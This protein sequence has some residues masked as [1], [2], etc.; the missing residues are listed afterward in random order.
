MYQQYYIKN[1]K[2]EGLAGPRVLITKKQIVM[3]V[4]EAMKNQIT[5]RDKYNSY[6]EAMDHLDN[7]GVVHLGWV[8]AGITIPAH[9]FAT[10]VYSNRS[11][12]SCLYCDPIYRVAYSVDMG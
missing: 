5:I 12:S 3:T 8:N 6:S 11:G 2:T 4:L 9:L 1:T 7:Q 10:K